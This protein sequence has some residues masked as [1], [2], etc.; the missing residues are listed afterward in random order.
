MF[1]KLYSTYTKDQDSINW[2]YLH[3]TNGFAESK[4]FSWI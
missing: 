2:R 1:R 4:N 3:G